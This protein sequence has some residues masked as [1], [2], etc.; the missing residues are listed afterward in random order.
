MAITKNDI[1]YMAKAMGWKITKEEEE[2]E[3]TVKKLTK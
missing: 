2:K 1:I 3:E